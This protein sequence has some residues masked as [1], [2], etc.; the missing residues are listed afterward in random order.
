MAH[1]YKYYLIVVF[2]KLL[3]GLQLLNSQSV[4][5]TERLREYIPPGIELVNDLGNSVD[6]REQISIPTIISF[7]Y[8]ECPGVCS[9]L[10]SEISHVIDNCE[11]VPGK[12]YQFFTISINPKDNTLLAHKRKISFLEKMQKKELAK[13]GWHFFTADSTNIQKATESLGFQYQKAG[14]EF[15]HK[16]AMIIVNSKG[17]ISRYNLGINM[18]PVELKISISE[19]EKGNALPKIYKNDEYC[20]PYVVPA[21]QRLNGV[22]RQAGIIIISFATGL[23][24]LL[25]L[26]PIIKNRKPIK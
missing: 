18:L 12:D 9:P 15:I 22:A 26:R 10:M 2:F 16:T 25:I 13:T 17:M 3:F 6:L 19:A 8:Y 4:E 23:F 14:E 11:L 24:L 20:Y 5:I 21:F 7:V 1:C